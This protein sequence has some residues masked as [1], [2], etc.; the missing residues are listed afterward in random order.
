[1]WEDWS[2]INKDWT[3]ILHWATGKIW[4]NNHAH[5]LGELSSL[6]RLKYVYYYLQTIDVTNIVRGMPPKINQENLRKII[7]P[8]PPLPIQEEIVKILDT[9]TELEVS[10]R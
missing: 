2:V 1:M 3:P 4:V 7:I 6:A 5:V 10:A 8:V 9:F